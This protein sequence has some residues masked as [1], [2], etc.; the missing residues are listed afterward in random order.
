INLHFLCHRLIHFDI[1]WSLMTFQQRNGRIDRYG[2]QQRPE[3]G[4]CYTVSANPGIRG[5]TR[6][7][8]LLI[9]KDE[10]AARNIGD[11]P[12]FSDVDGERGEE[13]CIGRA[14]EDQLTPADLETK[15]QGANTDFLA[16]LFGAAAPPTG[17]AAA[18]RTHTPVSLYPSEL[19][20]L[21]A[22]LES[23]KGIHD[24]DPE[25]DA[26]RQLVSI[27]PNDD[28]RR[29]LHRALPPE[30]VRQRLHLT[31]NRALVKQAIRSS[32][33][34]ENEWPEYQL[35]WELHPVVEWLNFR[36][37]VNFG[38]NCAPVVSLPAR[39][40]VG[41]AI[42]LLQG[43]LPNRR[44]QPL[45][46]EWFAVPYR[47][48]SRG[49]ILALQALLLRTGFAGP[50]VANPGATPELL[51]A[52][53]LLP[54]AVEAG[55]AYMAARRREFQAALEPRLAEERASLERL[56]RAQEQQLGLDFAGQL[57]P[58]QLSRR[59]QRQRKIEETFQRWSGW[60]EESLTLEQRPYLR[61]AAL[62]LAES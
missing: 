56:L 25:F 35:L 46:H 29:L 36:L 31:A 27:T 5:D 7:I 19:E 14:I 2:Q 37:L 3:I 26:D 11:P 21:S 17:A 47:G 16:L 59:A 62:F 40:E 12:T 53:D 32:R 28:L 38:R 18:A 34:G 60:V 54:D 57:L 4:Y 13:L 41:E 8:E 52:R 42:F 51:R 1:P 61:V 48:R 20:Y 9:E 30:A 15:I 55:R 6:I 23:L 24:L 45:V 39:L 10:Q 49:D 43:E 50:A 58:M 33:S 22:A 44:G